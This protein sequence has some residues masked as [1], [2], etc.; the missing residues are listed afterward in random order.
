MYTIISAT[1]KDTLNSSYLF[2]S[3]VSLGFLFALAKPS[4]EILNKYRK[5][6]NIVLFLI[7]VEMLLVFVYLGI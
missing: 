1:Y 2:V 3:L 6:S 7:L 5:S 4:Q